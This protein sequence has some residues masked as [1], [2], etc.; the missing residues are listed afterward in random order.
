M[1]EGYKAFLALLETYPGTPAAGT[2]QEAADA[3]MADK[4]SR[5]EIEAW[6][7]YEVQ[8]EE[9]QAVEL[10]DKKAAVRLLKKVVTKYR[11]TPAAEKAQYWID[12]LTE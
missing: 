2:A 9:A 10:E 7:F 3:L 6:Q 4:D 5:R 11:G 12:R 8:F 1:Y